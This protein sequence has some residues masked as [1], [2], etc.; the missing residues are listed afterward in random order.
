MDGKHCS[1]LERAT[2]M[3]ANHNFLLKNLCGPISPFNVCLLSLIGSV[4]IFVV[5]EIITTIY[6]WE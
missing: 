3:K 1:C 4:P 6:C 5:E 2:F